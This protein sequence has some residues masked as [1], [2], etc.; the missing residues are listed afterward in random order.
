MK[1]IL[2][3]GLLGIQFTYA[4]DTNKSSF[5]G[6][7]EVRLDILSLIATTKIQ[8]T[9]E[10]FLSQSFS[11]GLSGAVYASQSDKDDFEKGYDRTL[12]QTEITPFIRYTFPGNAT[13]FY[14]LEVFT[15]YNSGKHRELHRFVDSNNNGY[16]KSVEGNY[17]DFALGGA[18]GYKMYFK[19]KISLDLHVGVGKNLFNQDKSPDLISRVGA[20]IGYRF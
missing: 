11:V 8:L 10:H 7:N 14:F 16:Y 5:G 1:K 19:E 15:A 9:Y 18:I 3:I 6:N 4:Q 17:S 13:R 2:I 12:P 20:N